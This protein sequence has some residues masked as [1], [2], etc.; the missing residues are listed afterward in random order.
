MSASSLL[1]WFLSG[2]ASVA[3]QLN[4]SPL[5]RGGGRGLCSI[6]AWAGMCRFGCLFSLS[7]P[8]RL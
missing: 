3:P 1:L 5:V 2:C 7:P 8:Q 6:L 4:L